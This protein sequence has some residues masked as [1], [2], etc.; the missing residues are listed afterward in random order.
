MKP[1]CALSVCS[2]CSINY[3]VHVCSLK[4]PLGSLQSFLG[5]PQ[6]WDVDWEYPEVPAVAP[7]RRTERSLFAAVTQHSGVELRLKAAELSAPSACTHINS[8]HYKEHARPDRPPVHSSFYCRG[9]SISLAVHSILL[10][11]LS[12]LLSAV[13]MAFRSIRYHTCEPQTMYFLCT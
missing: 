12:L 13:L 11:L 1:V 4:P 6:Y 9:K 8:T 5:W 2:T 7:R 10:H 3:L